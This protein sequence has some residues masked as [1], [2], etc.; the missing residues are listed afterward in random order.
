MN[1]CTRFA[2]FKNIHLFLRSLVEGHFFFC[3]FFTF[4]FFFE[5]FSFQIVPAISGDHVIH[6]VL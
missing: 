5:F 3:L 1:L 6:R 2:S 4:K